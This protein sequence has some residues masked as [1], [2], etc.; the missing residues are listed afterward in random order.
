MG[1]IIINSQN[2]YCELLLASTLLWAGVIAMN[3]AGKEMYVL[4]RGERQ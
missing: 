1:V 2:H 3:K 4:V